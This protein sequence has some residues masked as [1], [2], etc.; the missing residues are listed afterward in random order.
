MSRRIHFAVTII[1]RVH[2]QLQAP[3]R[4]KLTSLSCFLLE[5]VLP[6]RVKLTAGQWLPPSKNRHF[7]E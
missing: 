1:T 5:D 2:T 6:E 7:T 3:L 4:V